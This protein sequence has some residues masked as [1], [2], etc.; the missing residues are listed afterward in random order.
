MLIAGALPPGVRAGLHVDGHHH[1][2]VD[3]QRVDQPLHVSLCV[4]RTQAASDRE[5]AEHSTAAVATRS[6]TYLDL[7]DGVDDDHDVAVVTGRQALQPAREV[8]QD[9]T[10]LHG[11]TRHRPQVLQQ[12]Q[13]NTLVTPGYTPC[14]NWLYTLVTPGYT[15]GYTWSH[16][17]TPGYTWSNL[18][19]PGHT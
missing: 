17:V 9:L 8:L 11:E 6:A 4:L 1:P 12:L 2:D 13:S 3:G 7:V 14:Y 19:T 18:V 16:L 5:P 10:G 15:P